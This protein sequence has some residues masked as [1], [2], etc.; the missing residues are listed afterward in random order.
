MKHKGKKRGKIIVEKMIQKRK[1]YLRT[2]LCT[3]VEKEKRRFVFVKTLWIKQMNKARLLTQIKEIETNT[4]N[5]KNVS[6][7]EIET[8]ALKMGNTKKVWFA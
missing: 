7:R 6:E 1:I 8:R 2:Y 5:T 4:L 3:E